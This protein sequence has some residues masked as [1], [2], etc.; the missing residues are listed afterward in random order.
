MKKCIVIQANGNNER[1]S[2]FFPQPKYEL[3]YNGKK[4]IHHIIENAKKLECDVYVVLNKKT[5]I[6][7]D[8]T[9][10]NVV[11]VDS[12]KFR[13]ET[14]SKCFENF[15]NYNEVIIHDCDV[16][17]PYKSLKKLSG[18]GITV[19]NY[20][21]DGLKYGFVMLDENFKFIK[22]NEKTEESGHITTGAYSVNYKKFENFIRNNNNTDSFWGYYNNSKEVN[23]VF[24]K[25]SINLGDINSY[26]DNLWSL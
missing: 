10:I 7:F 22:G 17:I 19:T 16:I 18:D 3:F 24:T 21:Y 20:K 11:L 12:T 15:K 5:K 4:I 26:M 13:L 14:L 25:N 9:G 6:N 8:T 1:M 23:L 2:K